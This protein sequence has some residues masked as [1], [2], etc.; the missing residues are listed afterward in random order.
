MNKIYTLLTA[1]LIAF[2]LPLM[3]QGPQ[4]PQDSKGPHDPNH[5]PMEMREG[6]RPQSPEQRK[7]QFEEIRT[8]QLAFFTA[9][10]GMTGEEASAFWSIYTDIQERR[11]KLNREK[12]NTMHPRPAHTPAPDG[13]NPPEQ[14]PEPN[15]KAGLPEDFD[16]K[17]AVEKLQEL[18]KQEAALDEEC[19]QKLSK[20]LP[21]EKLF[22]FYRAEEAWTRN[23]LN[24]FDR[25]R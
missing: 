10:I 23:L 7:Q 16:Y 24:N 21:S 11:W 5:R 9:E 22:K 18:S 1:S 14:R 15:A 6:G 3:A 2:A 12:Y 13:A 25:R 4:D 8:R 20:V 17:K 19:Y